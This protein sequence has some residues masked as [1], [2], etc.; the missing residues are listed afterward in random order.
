MEL[1]SLE[2]ITLDQAVEISIYHLREDEERAEDKATRL[3]LNR[4]INDIQQ[5][6][7][8]L[9]GAILEALEKEQK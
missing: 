5:A 2:L 9:N 1:S 6:K 8:K 7:S 4:Y 3:H